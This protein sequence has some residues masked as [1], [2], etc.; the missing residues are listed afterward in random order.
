MLT[1]MLRN[2]YR[3][4]AEN[5]VTHAQVSVSPARMLAGYHM[6][7]ASSF[8]F[9]AVGLPNNYAR[10]LPSV[11]V[12]GFECDAAYSRTAGARLWE[13]AAQGARELAQRAGESGVS[14]AV[15]RKA[16]QQRYRERLAATRGVGASHEGD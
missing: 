14:V 4:P 15:Y 7:W 5:C 9:E 2:R 12:F 10:A 11:A 6:D 13:G 3:I 16:Q 8:P 1:E